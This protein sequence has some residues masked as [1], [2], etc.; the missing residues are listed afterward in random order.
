MHVVA[1][2]FATVYIITCCNI[3]ELCVSQ[4]NVCV[5]V[6]YDRVDSSCLCVQ[7][8][9]LVLC[10]ESAVCFLWRTNRIMKYYDKVWRPKDITSP[11]NHTFGTLYTGRY[12]ATLGLILLEKIPSINQSI[13]QSINHTIMALR[14]VP[15]EYSTNSLL[16]V[17]HF[18]PI[19]P[20]P[21][22]LHISTALQIH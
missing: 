13:N 2:M 1:F 15:S 5:C 19:L 10:D 8:Y 14:L 21:H 3:K 12:R 18:S 6:L 22:S 9:L 16:H 4:R 7:L 11:P 20:L 17:T